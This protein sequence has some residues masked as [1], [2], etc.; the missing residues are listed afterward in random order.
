MAAIIL[1]VDP[2]IISYLTHLD[3]MAIM[4]GH[5]RNSNI[6]NLESTWWWVCELIKLRNHVHD[7]E[8]PSQ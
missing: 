2:D 8:R 6:F 7:L 3:F 5:S 4:R 1:I